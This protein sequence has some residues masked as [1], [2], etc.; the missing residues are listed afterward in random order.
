MEDVLEAYQRPLDP[1][2]P[3]VCMDESS[4]Q[5][6]K[7]VRTPIPA[8]PGQPERYDTEYQRNGISNLF[9]FFEPLT[10]QRHVAVTDSR[11]ALDWAHPIRHL[12]DV[13]HPDARQAALVMDNPNTHTPASLYKAFE[14]AEARRLLER[15]EIHY[16]PKHGSWPNRAE[17][18]FSHPNR[19]CLDRRIPDQATLQKETAAWVEKRNTSA[20]PLDWRFTTE[21]ARIKLKRPYPSINS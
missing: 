8:E 11:T 12:P 21:D 17:I 16:T 19:Q 7:E 10:G 18:E 6:I 2:Q 15:L 13:R 14:P 1:D 20:K 5:Q 9:M 3:L 4:K